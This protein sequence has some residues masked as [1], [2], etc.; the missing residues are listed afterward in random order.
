MHLIKPETVPSKDH[1][2]S[3]AASGAGL[4]YVD[5]SDLFTDDEKYI[6][7]KNMAEKT[8]SKRNYAAC[9]FIAARL[10]INSLPESPRQVNFI[11]SDSH[12]GPIDILSIFW[13]PD[14]TYWWHPH[15]TMHSKSADL[16]TLAYYTFTTIPYGVGVKASFSLAR[17]VIGR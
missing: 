8:L 14:I 3:A 4:S 9:L 11:F 5:S 17:E 12:F 16:S 2:P 13:V 7:P 6:T 10:Y 15:E 1:F